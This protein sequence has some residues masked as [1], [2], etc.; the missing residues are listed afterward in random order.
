MART[1]EQHQQIK[2]RLRALNLVVSVLTVS[3]VVGAFALSAAQPS[4]QAA[5]LGAGARLIQDGVD[6]VIPPQELVRI[7]WGAV[8]AGAIIAIVVQLALNLLALSVGA[9]SINPQYDQDS[10]KPQTL[11][12]GGAIYVGISTLMALFI[13]GWIASRFA[14]N[15]NNFDGILHGVLTWAVVM[16][17]TLFL[18]MTTLGR[19]ISGTA[20]LIGHGLNLA[21]RTTEAV[22]RGAVGA[23]QM[24]VTGAANVAG[25]A[26]SV[27][28]SAARGAVNTAVNA[29]ES[30]AQNAG[31]TL[32]NVASTLRGEIDRHPELQQAVQAVE[33]VVRQEV[34]KH[35]QMRD[36]LERQQL[37][38]ETIEHEARELLRQAGVSPNTLQNQAQGVAQ[39]VAGAAQTAAQQVG[40][41]DFEG[42]WGTVQLAMRHV[43]RE[44][45]DAVNE[46]DRD[47]LVQVLMQRA[48]VNEDQARQ[49]VQDWE[50]RFYEARNQTMQAR[51]QVEQSLNQMRAEA[52][53]RVNEVRS[54]I[55]SQ[56]Q[57]VQRDAERV[58]REAAQA[59]TDAISRL[60]AAVF[61]AMVIGALAAGIGGWLGTPAEIDTIE[62]DDNDSQTSQSAPSAAVNLPIALMERQ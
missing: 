39:D 35:P 17:V 52:E 25:A 28:G 48:N 37:S 41:G 27:A 18:L 5:D 21:G 61:A 51:Q 20:N 38:R 40:R 9:T 34:D 59:T 6:V 58:A 31:G 3:V 32:N 54:Q 4:F 7:S 29:A 49:T 22:A 12:V 30:G 36:A 23:T 13:G 42:A 26:A 47:R 55:E 19:I 44:G 57:Q 14:G 11:A 50:N 53:Q 62:V 46:V 33:N 24:A 8:L 60:A 1:H 45:Q 56:V 43:L 16:L 15:P 2:R 10:A